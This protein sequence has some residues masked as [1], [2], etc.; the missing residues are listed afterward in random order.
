MHGDGE[1][2]SL[3]SV[4]RACGLVAAVAVGLTAP[5][6][7][8]AVSIPDPET[9]VAQLNA[10]RAGVG[11][12]PVTY[13]DA[14]S[15]GCKKHA[16]YHRLNPTQRLHSED[17]ALA[18]YTKAG[19]SAAR[20]SVLVYGADPSAI[21]GAWTSAPYHRMA[22]LDPRLVASGFWS[23]F[24]ISCMHAVVL[25]QTLRTPVLAA[26]TYPAGGQRDVATTFWCNELPNPCDLVRRS[27]RGAPTG[28]NLS[29]Q[30]NGPWLR[31]EDVV[32]SSASVAAAGRPPVDLT[33]LSHERLLRGGLVLIPH[34]PLRAGTTYG[35]AA[36]GTVVARSDDGTVSEYPFALAWDFSTPGSGPAAS[37]KVVVERV[38][39]TRVHLR[40]DL[41]GTEPREARISL[42]HQRTPLVRVTRRLSGP[43]ERFSIRRPRERITSVGVLVRGSATQV[44]LA[45]RL[46]TDIKAVGVPAPAIAARR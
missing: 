32:V 15:R 41:L 5:A 24:G 30:F 45:S 40:V 19:D 25:D 17:P 26:Y 37:L 1:R 28:T 38:T 42:L 3:R 16:T 31:I 36:T 34:R 2:R 20:S 18:G 6:S 4:L 35:A 44:A 23:E 14:L 29:V 9:G 39:R 7:A 27:A 21:L 13:D 10:L 12:S 22:L 11:L 33:V 46:A 8:P 43:S